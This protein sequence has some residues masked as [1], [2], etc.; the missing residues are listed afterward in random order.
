MFSLVQTYSKNGW[1]QTEAFGVMIEHTAME[2][3]DD[4][5]FR[6]DLN[7]YGEVEVRKCEEPTQREF[8][9]RREFAGI[10]QKAVADRAG[11]RQ[12]YLSSWERGK[13]SVS[14]NWEK[15]VRRALSELEE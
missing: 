2:N 4:N 6:Y 11:V 13:K 7:T 8:R 9:N 1:S 12:V 10:T 15:K 5:W 14:E 3:A